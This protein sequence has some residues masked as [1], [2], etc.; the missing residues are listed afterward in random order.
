MLVIQSVKVSKRH[1]QI[2]YNAEERQ[3]VIIDLGSQNGTLLNGKAIS[4]VRNGYIVIKV[5]D[6]RAQMNMCNQSYSKILCRHKKTTGCSLIEMETGK[7][8]TDK[9]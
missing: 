7:S 3:Y 5:R 8:L 1:A 9:Q 2:V 6:G 4:E